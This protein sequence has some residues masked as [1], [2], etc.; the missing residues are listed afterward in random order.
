MA[1]ALHG[2]FFDIQRQPGK[3]K[4]LVN[5][6]VNTSLTKEFY[7][8]ALTHHQHHF[9]AY[10]FQHQETPSFY[11]EAQYKPHLEKHLS[12]F[13][14]SFYIASALYKFLREQKIVTIGEPRLIKA[15]LELEKGCFYQFE[16]TLAPSILVHDW[17]YLPF[18]APKRRLYK[19][20]DKQAAALIQ[21]EASHQQTY[22]NHDTVEVGDWIKFKVE[23]LD[24][25][26]QP[27]NETLYETLWLQIGE[28]ETSIPYKELFVGKKIHESF[29]T[30]AQC[31]QE[32][33]NSLIDGNYIFLVTIQSILP[34]KF[35]NLEHFKEHF[36]LKSEKK[37]HQK[38]VEVYSSKHDLSL[39]RSMVEETM[40]VLNQAYPLEIPASM[41][42]DQEKL[43]MQSVQNSP[44]YMVYR[45]L[46]DFADMITKLAYKQVL[47]TI[48]IDHFAYQENISLSDAEVEYYLNFT[49]RARTKEFLHFVHPLIRVNEEET[50]IS[51][52]SL[53][54][55]CLREKTLNHILYHLNKL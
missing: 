13:I 21:E 30:K 5:I 48:L 45:Q 8:Q 32:Y 11:V 26:N 52:E 31:L 29:M 39:R 19:D 20:I 36:K 35:F 40:R 53:K 22:G 55:V 43:I 25:N 54:Q 24:K 16:V 41:I 18:K 6:N 7:Q 44:D 9:T 50:P 2:L 14:F 1:E 23:L 28:E 42:A 27:M 17:K 47:E 33:F 3:Q 49:K 38:V 15:E 37:V 4:A 12:E 34:K 10:G 46:P 51:H